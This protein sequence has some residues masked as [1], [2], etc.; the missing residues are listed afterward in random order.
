MSINTRRSESHS[1]TGTFGLRRRWV[2]LVPAILVIYI[3][4]YIDRVNISFAISRL[5]DDLGINSAQAGFAAG[6]FFIGYLFLQVPGGYL[7]QRWSVK[8]LIIILLVAWGLLAASCGLVQSYGAL[9]V[10]RFLLGL[11]EG[12][13]Q[14]ALMVLITRWFPARERGRAFALFIMHNPIAVIIAGPLSGVILTFGGWRAL[15]IIEGLGGLV[16]GLLVWTLIAADRPEQARWMKPAEVREIAELKGE[17]PTESVASRPMEAVRSSAVWQLAIAA[18]FVWLGF[19]GLQLWL[20][21]LLKK[22]FTGDLTI[23]LVSAIPPLVAA[24]AIWLNGRGADRDKRYEIRVL[25]PLVLGGIVLIFSTMI[26]GEQ[27]VLLVAA[28]AVATACQLS[29]FGPFWSLASL[30]VPAVAVGVGY[31]MIN[32]IGNLGGLLGPYLGGWLRDSTGS[33][34]VSSALFGGSVILAGLI[35]GLFHFRKAPSPA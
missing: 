8:K 25:V 17:Q 2:V 4:A 9:L 26:T 13:V 29:F 21:T 1:E 10:V 14:P 24:V 35:V 16:I 30:R 28:L 3:I 15:F 33:L 22:S 19:Y 34:L 31:G 20:P 27:R 6:I 18:L 32:G 11:I 5:Q 12:A 23:G 7:A